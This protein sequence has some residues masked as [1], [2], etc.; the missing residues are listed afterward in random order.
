[1]FLSFLLLF[2]S[3][4]QCYVWPLSYVFN[5]Y[6]EKA[7]FMSLGIEPS[8]ASMMNALYHLAIKVTPFRYNCYPLKEGTTLIKGLFL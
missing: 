6:I 1:M 3:F 2:L 8:V 4:N 7:A 5:Y